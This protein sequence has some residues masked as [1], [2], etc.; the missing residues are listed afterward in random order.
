MCPRHLV[1]ALKHEL[2]NLSRGYSLYIQPSI[3]HVY[4]N[5]HNRGRVE[6]ILPL[7]EVGL[8]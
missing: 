8:S 7:S 1:I 5:V 2:R 3:L 4:M 6:E